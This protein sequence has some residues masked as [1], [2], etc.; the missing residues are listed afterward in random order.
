MIC[1]AV[2]SGRFGGENVVRNQS[3]NRWET[4][5]NIKLGNDYLQHTDICNLLAGCYGK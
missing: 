4:F 5:L 2:N 3:A 1:G